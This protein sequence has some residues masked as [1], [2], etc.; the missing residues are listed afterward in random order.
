MAANIRMKMTKLRLEKVEWWGWEKV[1]RLRELFEESQPDLRI[2]H[3]I[4]EV[5]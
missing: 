5:V 3:F 1:E 4:S 2:V